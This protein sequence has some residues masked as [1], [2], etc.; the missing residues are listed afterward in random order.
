MPEAQ[1]GSWLLEQA[2][3]IVVMGIVIW[4]LA[5]RLVKSETE[6]DEM[7]KDV[8]KITTLWESKADKMSDEDEATKREIISLL[9]D[10][11]ASLPIK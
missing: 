4:W 10:I 6:K 11:K 8:I 2:P 9:H 5:K 1:V 3:V 7:A